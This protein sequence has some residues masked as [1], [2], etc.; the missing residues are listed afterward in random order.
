MTGNRQEGAPRKV[1]RNQVV[2]PC[3]QYTEALPEFAVLRNGFLVQQNK[4]LNFSFFLF[5]NLI[6]FL[7]VPVLSCGTEDL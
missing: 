3:S 2:Q 7:A 4:S 6:Y 1:R 5:F